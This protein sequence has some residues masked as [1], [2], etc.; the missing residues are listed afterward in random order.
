[1]FSPNNCLVAASTDEKV[2]LWNAT[3]G[4]IQHILDHSVTVHSVAFSPD[5]SKVVSGSDGNIVWIWD[6]ATGTLQQTFKSHPFTDPVQAVAFSPD[7]SMVISGC[8]DT[9]VRLWDVTSL[10]TG[11]LKQVSEP[12]H[13]IQSE[14]VTSMNFSPDGCLVVS[15]SQDNRVRLWDVRNGTLEKTLEPG[16]SWP[17]TAVMFSPHGRLIASSSHDETVR[18]WNATTGALEQILDCHS[19]GADSS[20][21]S[22]MRFSPDSCRVVSGS[23]D[24]IVRL[25]DATTGVLQHVLVG[26]SD[27][28]Y[29]VIFS[30]NGHLVASGSS[31]K[32]V[33]LWDTATGALQHVLNGQSSWTYSIA[34]TLDSGMVISFC[35][36]NTVWFWDTATGDLLWILYNDMAVFGPHPSGPELDDKCLGIE[37]DSGSIETWSEYE[38]LHATPIETECGVPSIRGEWV[39]LNGEE[40]LWLP[41]EYRQSNC[42]TKSHDHAL[43]FGHES[44]WVSTMGFCTEED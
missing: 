42:F 18:V 1:M 32:T 30:P 43:A 24:N 16:H 36:D 17:V 5:S 11:A 10:N 3:T 44:G 21:V 35:Q 37:L 13:L 41:L 4:A 19:D 38:R 15:G 39:T 20:A 26:H 33:R 7:G 2:S 31:D 34:F 23:H 27:V 9:T 8:H 14:S 40:V 6:I 25:W 28:V 22:S 29:S 12:G